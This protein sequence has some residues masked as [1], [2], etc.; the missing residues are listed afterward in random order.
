MQVLDHIRTAGVGLA[1]TV[2]SRNIALICFRSF[3]VKEYELSSRLLFRDEAGYA[4]RA[5]VTLLEEAP[6][7]LAYA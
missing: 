7:V 6:C 2:L 5:R 1:D 3:W 4:S